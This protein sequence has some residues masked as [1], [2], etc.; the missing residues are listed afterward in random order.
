MLLLTAAVYFSVNTFYQVT[1]ARLEPGNTAVVSQKETQSSDIQDQK[2]LSH[3]QPIIDRNLFN[4]KASTDQTPKPVDIETLKETDLELTLWGTVTGDG[5]LTYAVIEDKKERKQS[6]YRAGDAIQNARVKMVLREKVILTVD[7]KDEV[8][9]MEEMVASQPPKREI[10]RISPAR[11]LPQEASSSIT[12]ERSAVE[13]AT[14][15]LN[16]LMREVRIRP[17]F[18]EGK[19]DGLSLTGMKPGSLFRKMGLHNGDIIMGVDGKVI[20]SVDDALRFYESLKSASELKLEIQRRGRPLT[21][22][23]TFE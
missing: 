4:T 3:Y 5:G 16:N 12:L 14:K 2:P 1:T 9:Q 22:N 11:A 21:L 15:D 6:L 8:L 7:G 17:H 13:D 19:P 20:T 18:K 23:Y 10:R